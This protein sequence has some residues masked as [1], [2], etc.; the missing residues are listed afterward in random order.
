MSIGITP[1][2]ANALRALAE[3]YRDDLAEVAALPLLPSERATVEKELKIMRDLVT[4]C[5][6]AQVRK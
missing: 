6:H 3:L 1:Q 4:F 2:Q 5:A